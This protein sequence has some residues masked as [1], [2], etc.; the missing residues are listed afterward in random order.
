MAA[1]ELVVVIVAVV[2]TPTKLVC[3]ETIFCSK[4]HL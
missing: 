3:K 1:Q 4:G 2:S